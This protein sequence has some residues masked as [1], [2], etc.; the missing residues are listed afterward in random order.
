MRKEIGNKDS[1][2]I[3]ISAKIESEIIHMKNKCRPWRRVGTPYYQAPEVIKKYYSELCDEWS[4]GIV[5]HILIV[6]YLLL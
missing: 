4:V 2:I 3:I 5:Y 6:Q 1:E